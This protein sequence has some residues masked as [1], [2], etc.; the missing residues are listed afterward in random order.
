MGR[1]VRKYCV[2]ERIRHTYQ[3]GQETEPFRPLFNHFESFDLQ[4]FCTLFEGDE[5]VRRRKKIGLVELY[6]VSNARK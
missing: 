3:K 1:S 6:A 2:D 4:G 5:T